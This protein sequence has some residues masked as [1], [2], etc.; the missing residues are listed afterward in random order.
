MSRNWA[1]A[2]DRYQKAR[3]SDKHKDSEAEIKRVATELE[4]WLESAEGRQAKLLLAASGRHIVLA[5]E[6]GAGGHGTVY[7]LDKDGLKRSTEAMGLWTAYAR[8]D[9][10]SS[11][12]VEQVTSLEV[13]QA[14]SREGN[15][16]LAQFFL[17]LRRKID[18]IADAAP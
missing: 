9:K 10:I 18:A 1:D 15:A 4:Q 14:V 5:E 13:I 12:S 7:F 17:W 2:T 3:Q 16:I 6:E 11:P 8:K